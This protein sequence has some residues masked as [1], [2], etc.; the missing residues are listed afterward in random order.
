MRLR[1]E[2]LVSM[3]IYGA[4]PLCFWNVQSE[5]TVC[6]E[7]RSIH[8]AE[9]IFLILFHDGLRTGLFN[10]IV[11]GADIHIVGCF[12]LVQLQQYN[13]K[14]RRIQGFW[15]ILEWYQVIQSLEGIYESR[16]ENRLSNSCH[17]SG[18]FFFFFCQ[19]ILSKGG[20]SWWYKLVFLN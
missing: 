1:Y 15:P 14:C 4:A 20:L 11:I 10:V 8:R 18:P 7:T 9:Y 3:I 5:Y 2:H 6:T 19:I 13:S 17:W 12:L 16:M